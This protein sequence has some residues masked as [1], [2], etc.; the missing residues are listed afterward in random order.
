VWGLA[1]L[2]KPIAL[3]ILGL[4]LVLCIVRLR[5]HLRPVLVMLGVAIL[6]VLPWCI[7]NSIIDGRPTLTQRSALGVNLLY[8]T[9]TTEE[10]GKDIWTEAL[11]RY[12]NDHEDRDAGYFRE[13]LTRLNLTARVEQYPRLFI[14]TGANLTS[15]YTV[16]LLYV[17]LQL[18]LG[19]LAIMGISGQPMRF[20]IVPLFLA[21]FHIPLW[22]ETRYLLPAVPFV[23]VFIARGV[24]RVP[25]ILSTGASYLP[26]LLA[27]RSNAGN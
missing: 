23:C 4:A 19:V 6:V 7:R 16:R 17:L 5:H 18:G 1:A 27:R 25:H 14:D 22:I 10:F 12:P 8:G 26:G 20:W 9:F 24:E 11:R 2:T 21:L 13:A 3:P 15:N